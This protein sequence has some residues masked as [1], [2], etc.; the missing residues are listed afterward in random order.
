MGDDETYFVVGRRFVDVSGTGGLSSSGTSARTFQACASGRFDQLMLSKQ[1][2]ESVTRKTDT[3]Q[4]T[5]SLDSQAHDVTDDSL[6]VG[7]R[8][9]HYPALC[10]HRLSAALATPLGRPCAACIA[11]SAAQPQVPTVRPGRRS[12]HRQ[13]GWLRLQLLRRQHNTGG[14]GG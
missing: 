8:T 14:M 12:R 5:C 6:I 11:V 10:G 13:P 2:G 3:I 9:G 1:V 4:I 7:Q